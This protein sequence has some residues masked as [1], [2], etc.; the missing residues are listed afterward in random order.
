MRV[1]LRG[2]LR[3]LVLLSISNLHPSSAADAPKITESEKQHCTEDYKKFCGE[4]GLD[5]RLGHAEAR[6]AKA[7]LLAVRRE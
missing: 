2:L 5:L 1:V 4:Y 6:S 3:G 7:G